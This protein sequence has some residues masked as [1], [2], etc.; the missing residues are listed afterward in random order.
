[1]LSS[2]IDRFPRPPLPFRTFASFWIKAF[3]RIGCQSTRLPNPPDFLSLPAAVSITSF[4]F[5][6]KFQDRY[7]SGGLLFLK[8]LGTFSTMI[9]KPFQVNLFCAFSDTFSQSLFGLFR[10]SY[11]EAL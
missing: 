11:S 6:S 5:G 10:M 7:V 3:N 8:P 9:P 1:L 4:G 2:S